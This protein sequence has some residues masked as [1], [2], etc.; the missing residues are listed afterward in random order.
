MSQEPQSPTPTSPLETNSP[1]EFDESQKT[2]IDENNP[3]EPNAQDI[4]EDSTQEAS[5]EGSNN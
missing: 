3:Q 5:S 4:H 2:P 1:I